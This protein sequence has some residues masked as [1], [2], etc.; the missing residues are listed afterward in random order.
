MVQGSQNGTDR[1]NLRDKTA[2][3]F[4]LKLPSRL[5]ATVDK[6]IEKTGVTSPI[7]TFSELTGP[8]DHVRS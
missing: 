1:L 2:K 5:L 4:G 7:G 3:T 8:A 6:V